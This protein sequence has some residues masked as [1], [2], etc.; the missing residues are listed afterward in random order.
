ME[1]TEEEDAPA[2]EPVPSP[3]QLRRP[4]LSRMLC[5]ASAEMLRLSQCSIT[6]A[7]FLRA[8]ACSSSPS[9]AL[10]QLHCGHS[11]TAQ[12]LPLFQGC[13]THCS[14][15]RTCNKQRQCSGPSMQ[16]H[17]QVAIA[18]AATIPRGRGNRLIPFG[19]LG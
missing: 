2:A 9:C 5:R 10:W 18:T 11:V 8:S 6:L 13:H 3:L 19:L 14:C 1:E 12:R 15:G 7:T 4:L 16:A 17:Q